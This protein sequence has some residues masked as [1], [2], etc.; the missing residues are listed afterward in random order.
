MCA[1]EV[2]LAAASLNSGDCFVLK[3]SVCWHAITVGKKVCYCFALLQRCAPASQ[4]SSSGMNGTNSSMQNS[5]MHI[6]ECWA[7]HVQACVCLGG[8]RH[9]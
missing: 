9:S 3:V 1:V 2:D 4:R 5:S 7:G 6:R 8:A